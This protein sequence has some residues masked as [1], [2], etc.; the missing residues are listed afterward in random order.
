MLLAVPIF[1][2]GYRLIREDVARRNKENV[3]NTVVELGSELQNCEES[4]FVDEENEE[5]E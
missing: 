5:K 4:I 3:E 2:A 1:A